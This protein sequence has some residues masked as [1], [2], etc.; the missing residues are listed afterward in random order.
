MA[1]LPIGFFAPLPLAIM[2]PFMAAQSFAMGHAFGTSF[3]Y[4][5]RKI[6]SMSN[7]EFNAL[8]VTDLHDTL[9]AD[10]RGMIPSMN[11]S[12][13]R[14]ES[15]QIEI[16]QSMLNTI[17]KSV[18]AF[19]KWVTTGN[20][21]TTATEES[22]GLVTGTGGEH[23]NPFGIPEWLPHAHGEDS[24][25]TPTPQ[26]D[27]KKLTAIEKYASRWINYSNNTANWLSISQKEMDYLFKQKQLGN[28]PNTSQGL[29]NAGVKLTDNKFKSQTLKDVPKA[30][31]KINPNE[32]IRIIATQFNTILR[33]LE[34]LKKQRN[35]ANF[36]FALKHIKIYNRYVQAN[37][38]RNLT[39]DANKTLTGRYKIVKRF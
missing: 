29:I 2:I 32:V 8:N 6:S 38:H 19:G 39:I 37:G 28:M 11:E 26:L 1:I 36:A 34:K 15:F 21:G 22:E 20:I 35:S 13:H 27:T 14:M 9:Q 4:G 12:F 5:K 16:I 24:T 3:Q 31:S 33:A 23:T 25:F 17:T 10:I 18:D 7:E 30:I